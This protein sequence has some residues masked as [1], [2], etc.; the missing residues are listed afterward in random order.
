M[1]ELAQSGP[2]PHEANGAWATM[3]TGRPEVAPFHHLVGVSSWHTCPSK[4]AAG[5]EEDRVIYESGAEQVAGRPAMAAKS[6]SKAALAEKGQLPA[7]VHIKYPRP[8]RGLPYP[9]LYGHAVPR[10]HVG[11]GVKPGSVPWHRGGVKPARRQANQIDQHRPRNGPDS[12]GREVSSVLLNQ[13]REFLD[14]PIFEDPILARIRSVPPLRQDH[15]LYRHFGRWDESNAP[16]GTA[17]ASVSSGDSRPRTGQTFRSARSRTPCRSGYATGSSKASRPEPP[18]QLAWKPY[19]PTG[20]PFAFKIMDFEKVWEVDQLLLVNERQTFFGAS[21]FRDDYLRKKRQQEVPSDRLMQGASLRAGTQVLS[22]DNRL[23]PNSPVVVE[24]PRAGSSGRDKSP[25]VASQRKANRM[26]RGLMCTKTAT[27]NHPAASGAENATEGGEE[28]KM[29]KRDIPFV[30]LHTFDESFSSPQRLTPVSRRTVEKA[31]FESG[32]QSGGDLSGTSRT[33]LRS[34]KI[35]PRNSVMRGSPD[36][37]VTRNGDTYTHEAARTELIQQLRQ[38]RQ[39]QKWELQIPPREERLSIPG[40]VHGEQILLVSES[41]DTEEF[42]WD[43]IN[44]WWVRTFPERPPFKSRQLGLPN[45]K[46]LREQS[47][48]ERESRSRSPT[49]RMWTASYGSRNVCPEDGKGGMQ[50]DVIEKYGMLVA[51]EKFMTNLRQ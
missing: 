36:Q 47:R 39:R 7:D 25:L 17:T 43:D 24:H 18:G 8:R 46:K 44:K 28:R 3:A 27:A 50:E 23:S 33:P 37:S 45:S 14:M 38:D 5:E 31:G 35:S 20:N 4:A 41:G 22:G 34:P 32:A 15:G 13:S 19:L 6:S 51:Q 21:T 2:A 48:R 26:G 30:D 10:Q 1:E 49:L 11:A 29:E 16:A 12:P 40:R 9:Q 42:G